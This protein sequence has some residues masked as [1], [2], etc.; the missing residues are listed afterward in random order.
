MSWKVLKNQNNL[1]WVVMPEEM[2]TTKALLKQDHIT[3]IKSI[4]IFIGYLLSANIVLY[5]ICS[6]VIEV[7][8]I[9][10]LNKSYI[11]RSEHPKDA[12]QL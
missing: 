1:E 7:N 3:S 10:V 9:N 2:V 5:Y 4:H 11:E 6:E 8:A 12:G